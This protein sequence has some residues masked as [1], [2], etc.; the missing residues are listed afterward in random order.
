VDKGLKTALVIGGIIV[1]VL[2][3]LSVIPGL[4]GGWQGY[5]YGMMGPGMMGDLENGPLLGMKDFEQ[6]S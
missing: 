6:N 1:G 4:F 2:I 5:G 3:I